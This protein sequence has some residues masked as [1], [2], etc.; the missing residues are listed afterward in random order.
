MEKRYCT[1]VVLAL[2]AIGSG[3]AVGEAPDIRWYGAEEGTVVREV[4]GGQTG[5]I[6]EHWKQWGNVRVEI[7]DLTI[8]MFGMNRQVKQTSIIEG[9]NVTTIDYITG[10]IS[11]ARNPLLDGLG[12]GANKDGVATGE[13]MYRA[14][15]GE[16]T[17]EVREYA[18]ERCR[19]W[20]MSSMG[21]H[22]CVTKDGISLFDQ[23]DAMGMS[24]TRVASDIQRGNPGPGT[25]YVVPEDLVPAAQVPALQG[26]PDLGAVL[27]ALQGLGKKKKDDG[28]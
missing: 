1:W 26:A 3:P 2:T 24:S 25:A 6:T 17:D 20:R 12:D 8:T 15:G 27:E 22:S 13:A 14:M 28:D 10:R 21:Q 9:A 5:M 4:S 11:Q 7:Q 19:V 23:V 18:G 16:Q